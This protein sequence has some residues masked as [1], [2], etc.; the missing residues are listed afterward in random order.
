MNIPILTE[1]CIVMLDHIVS[2]TL[3]EENSFSIVTLS[4]GSTCVIDLTPWIRKCDKKKPFRVQA[5]NAFALMC[6]NACMSFSF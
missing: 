5:Y 2:I 1:D 6:A 4:D 3:H